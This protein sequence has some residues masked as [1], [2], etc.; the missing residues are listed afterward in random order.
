[1]SSDLLQWAQSSNGVGDGG[2]QAP[3]VET[4]PPEQRA[5]M[6]KSRSRPNN[7]R[8]KRTNR[9]PPLETPPWDML[10]ETGYTIPP[11]IECMG[12]TPTNWRRGPKYQIWRR[13]VHA[14]WGYTCHLCG[15]GNANTADHLVP[16]SVWPN[17][18]YDA[19]LS[20]PAH[21]V[22]GCATCGIKCNSSRG[23]KELA[24][25]VGNYQ[26]AIIL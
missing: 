20:R 14:I 22:Q 3:H 4:L 16:L 19:R 11:D 25:E 21:G 23:N 1:M 7:G 17:Q 2:G 24:L 10:R 26:P 8:K 6:K 15:H 9:N 13:E 5:A 18:P 12:Y